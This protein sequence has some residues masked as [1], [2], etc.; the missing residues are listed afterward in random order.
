[1]KKIL[2]IQI[3]LFKFYFLLKLLS[4]LFLLKYLCWYF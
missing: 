3:S 1:M 4:R 2:F